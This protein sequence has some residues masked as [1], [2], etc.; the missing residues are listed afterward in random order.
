[1]SVHSF[2]GSV[3]SGGGFRKP[4]ASS[5]VSGSTAGTIRTVLPRNLSFDP[6]SSFL[7]PD[8]DVARF[9]SDMRHKVPLSSLKNDLEKYLEWVQG[10]MVDLI[11]RDYSEFIGVSR[12]ISDVGEAIEKMKTPLSQL[13]TSMESHYGSLEKSLQQIQ[14]KLQ[15]R[16]R[17]LVRKER[18]LRASSAKQRL[19]DAEKLVARLPSGSMAA[20][21]A[22]FEDVL[23]DV[24]VLVEVLI[25]LRLDAHSLKH[26][27]FGF[28]L[29]SVEGIFSRADHFLA[30]LLVHAL[31]AARVDYAVEILTF[32]SQ[33]KMERRAEEIL[34]QHVHIS[35]LG[36]FTEALKQNS[37]NAEKVAYVF[38]NVV[39]TVILKLGDLMSTVDES[40]ELSAVYNIVGNSIWPTVS[41]LICEKLPFIFS[42]GLPDAFQMYYNMSLHLLQRF[43]AMCKAEG[44]R[45][46]LF[47]SHATTEFKSR[48]NTS[49]YFQLRFQEIVSG[50]EEQLKNPLQLCMGTVENTYH[51]TSSVHC[52]STIR[53]CWSDDVF[54]PS[55]FLRMLRLTF[56]ICSRFF[57]CLRD[58]VSGAS[59]KFDV[60]LL[61]CLWIQHDVQTFISEIDS[62]LVPL[63]ILRSKDLSTES[64]L[65]QKFAAAIQ[66]CQTQI[67]GLSS[68]VGVR[69]VELLSTASSEALKGLRS[70]S[71]MY[72]GT[73]KVPS[74][75]LPYVAS[76]F[77]PMQRFVADARQRKISEQVTVSWLTNA[78]EN[79]ARNFYDGASELLTAVRKTQTSLAKL[80]SHKA[81]PLSAE[82]NAGDLSDLKRVCMQ[83]SF[84][85]E[86][87]SRQCSVISE[88]RIVGTSV[89]AV[90]GLLKL[91]RMQSDVE[92][93]GVNSFPNADVSAGETDLLQETNDNDQTVVETGQ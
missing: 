76:V 29:S 36:I 31:H 85:V 70:I 81:K 92:V 78:V 32:F 49:V 41:S 88:G 39:T 54:I 37:Q 13:Y 15:E 4:S 87:F 66:S 10:E 45:S 27:P 55:L 23:A 43:A 3:P 69:V 83:L 93:R 74:A 40:E 72:R 42:P 26:E 59:T 77:V 48:W 80:M 34:S 6:R 82:G 2:S 1:M 12:A 67:G 71:G 28:P 35:V 25:L 86:E 21:Q 56:Q 79:V 24:A 47:S 16:V 73:S 22:V 46:Y 33:L 17:L 5:V 19:E 8:F 89:S 53:R 38:E 52:F 84:D 7:S 9:V 20:G 90:S 75:P 61:T 18:V 57:S 68:V 60:D 58:V 30:Q 11:N 51:F 64:E 63:V 91:I 14:E 62:D 65:S 50:L 44:Q